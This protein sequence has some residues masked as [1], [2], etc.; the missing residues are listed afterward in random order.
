MKSA[1]EFFL[2]TPHPTVAR[3]EYM[4]CAKCMFQ[5]NTPVAPLCDRRSKA[6]TSATMSDGDGLKVLGLLK[7]MDLTKEQHNMLIDMVFANKCIEEV[8]KRWRR[9]G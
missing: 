5:K 7:E 6:A 9:V 4:K 1:H 3:R 2:M 8:F